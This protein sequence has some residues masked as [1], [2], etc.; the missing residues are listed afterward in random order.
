ME[1]AATATNNHNTNNNE[2]NK[3]Q[4]HY[5]TPLG[6]ERTKLGSVALGLLLQIAKQTELGVAQSEEPQSARC[7]VCHFA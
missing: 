6:P 7:I 4:P 3:E 2:H 5:R 1:S